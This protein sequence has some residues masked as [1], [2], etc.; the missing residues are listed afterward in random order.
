MTDKKHEFESIS[1]V[2][3]VEDGLLKGVVSIKELLREHVDTPIS[4]IMNK[5]LVTTHPGATL[6]RAAILAIQHNI[7]AVPVQDRAG[8][9]LGVVGTDT[10]LHTLHREHTEDLLRIGGVEI[11]EQKHILGMLHDR[12]AHL[13]RIRLNWLV[14]GLFGGFVAT[15][16]VSR[17]EQAL[18]S[19]VALAFFMPLVIYMASAVGAQTQML[20]IR[21]STIK[22]LALPGYVAKEFVVDLVL[23]VLLA[24]VLFVFASVF[25]MRADLAF[26]VA[27]A[28]AI[29]IVLAG[30]VA[31]FIPWLLIRF[32]RDPALGA[33]PFATVVQDILSLLV[34]FLV[35]SALL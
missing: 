9:F 22:K 14:L 18:A 30:L 15:F 4:K 5:E 7:K 25:T 3:V 20:F 34:Y 33:G 32:K 2:Y 8:K 27:V 26:A 31:I 24:V 17:F 28:M 11:V 10:I 16:V 23:A 35:A 19:T 29:A 13:I 12:V 1:Y 21:A 6:E